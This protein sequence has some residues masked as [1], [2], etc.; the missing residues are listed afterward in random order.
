MEGEITG[1]CGQWINWNSP[2]SEAVKKYWLRSLHLL[3]LDVVCTD[4][5]STLIVS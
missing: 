2:P 4:K 1:Y 3:F 5:I